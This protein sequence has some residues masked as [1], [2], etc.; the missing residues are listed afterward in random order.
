MGLEASPTTLKRS[1]GS[2]SSNLNNL[3]SH[4]DKTWRNKSVLRKS[5]LEHTPYNNQEKKITV[6]QKLSMCSSIEGLTY[7]RIKDVFCY[8]TLGGTTNKK[9]YI[10]IQEW[11][12]RSVESSFR[13]Q[14]LQWDIPKIIIQ[15][16][17]ERGNL[18]IERV[19]QYK[20]EH[21][22]MMAKAC[23][24]WATLHSDRIIFN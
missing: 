18:F 19:Y 24:N 20:M 9:D 8:V 15:S 14:K 11:V 2:F 10:Q 21:Y 16:E 7:L 17:S 13:Q 12:R 22:P 4:S 23:I 5:S 1:W 6:Q 3:R